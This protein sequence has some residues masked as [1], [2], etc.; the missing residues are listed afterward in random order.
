ML[1]EPSWSFIIFLTYSSSGKPGMEALKA[2]FYLYGMGEAKAADL[3]KEKE[4]FL[5]C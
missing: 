3:P 4:L 1:L 5:S 2:Y